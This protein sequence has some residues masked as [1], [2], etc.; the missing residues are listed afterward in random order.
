MMTRRH[1]QQAADRIAEHDDRQQA[2]AAA[3][4]LASIFRESNPRFNRDRFY[5]AGGLD[6]NGKPID[7]ANGQPNGKSSDNS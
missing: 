5:R 1:F 3:E 2:Q 7:K 6:G 4:I